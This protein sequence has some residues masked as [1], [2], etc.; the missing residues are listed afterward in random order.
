MSIDIMRTAGNVV[1]TARFGSL[2]SWVDL[3]NTNIADGV[4]T[5]TNFRMPTP[6]SYSDFLDFSGFSFNIPVTSTITG[7]TVGMIRSNENGSN[8][9]DERVQLLIA[10]V[11]MGQNKAYTGT[12]PWSSGSFSSVTYGG[13]ADNWGL[14][15]NAAIVNNNNF[16]LR[17]AVRRPT[18][19]G[20]ANQTPYLDHLFITVS[21]NS[22][23]PVELVSFQAEAISQREVEIQW[24]TASEI[25]S[26]HFDLERSMDGEE[27]STVTQI[28][29]AGYSQSLLEY[30]YIDNPAETGTIYYRLL[31]VDRD[32]A[33]TYYGPISTQSLSSKPQDF[34]LYPNPVNTQFQIN[35]ETEESAEYTV[36]IF[37]STGQLIRDRAWNKWQTFD[38][39][40]LNNGFYH[41]LVFEN[42]QLKY[43]TSFSKR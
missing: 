2:V 20:S 25:N 33:K 29:A 43:R 37:N 21:Y 15:L 5:Q 34:V 22:T 9:F 10:G 11:P 42:D 19:T 13:S 32:G 1:N 38:A 12:N 40:T 6:G 23:L 7:L 28:P 24:S 14:T 3:G 17:V 4:Y 31:Q 39:T 26:S 36:K 8:L 16:G 18:I 35:F 30:N 27:F 41:L